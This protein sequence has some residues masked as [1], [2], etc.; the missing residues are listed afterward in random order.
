MYKRQI[1]QPFDARPIET[2]PAVAIGTKAVRSRAAFIDRIVFNQRGE[3]AASN[4]NVGH[5][6]AG[7]QN[8]GVER[9]ESRNRLIHKIAKLI[10]GQ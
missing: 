4:A 3:I 9:I 7:I 2:F 6:H 5:S 8:T 10:P 1:E